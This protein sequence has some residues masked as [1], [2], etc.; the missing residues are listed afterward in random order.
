MPQVF[1]P[2]YVGIPIT[3]TF[4]PS[5]PFLVNFSAGFSS[6]DSHCANQFYFPKKSSE[7]GFDH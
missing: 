1:S 3:P 4:S 7:N 2:W 5:V 6:F